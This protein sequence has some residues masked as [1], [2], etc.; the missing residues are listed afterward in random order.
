MLLNKIEDLLI[1]GLFLLHTLKEK[2]NGGSLQSDSSK[3]RLIH[4]SLI[5]S[6]RS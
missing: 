4:S 2:C 6:G 5:G 3:F 1:V